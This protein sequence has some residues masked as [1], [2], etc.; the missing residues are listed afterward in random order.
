VID[1]G[2]YPGQC[3]PGSERRAIV[4]EQPER[5]D[6]IAR[7]QAAAAAATAALVN[8]VGAGPIRPDQLARIGQLG[9]A[10]AVLERR[11]DELRLPPDLAAR[12][13]RLRRRHERVNRRLAAV[14]ARLLA[15]GE[16]G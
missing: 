2:Y 15:I 4:A 14:D 12:V 1:P 16:E 8:E 10:L 6:L 7:L 13:E 5:P 11:G 9:H 3:G